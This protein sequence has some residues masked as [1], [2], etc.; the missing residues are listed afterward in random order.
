MTPFVEKSSEAQKCI[1]SCL[2][3]ALLECGA[4]CQSVGITHEDFDRDAPLYV[5]LMD[6]WSRGE[7]FDFSRIGNRLREAG[8]LDAIGGPS[9]LSEIQFHAGTPAN[10]H[11]YVECLLEARAARLLANLGERLRSAA[12]DAT[13]DPQEL[14]E[15]ARA[16]LDKIHV[17]PETHKTSIGHFA[18]QIVADLEEPEKHRHAEV[19]EI[20][21]GLDEGAGPF[22]R[23]DLVVIAGRTKGGKSSFAGNLIENCAMQAR[24][25]AMFSFEMTGKQN[26]SRMLASRSNVDI[27]D[28]RSKLN[29]D[30]DLFSDQDSLP[31]FNLDRIRTVAKAMKTWK[32]EIF[33]HLKGIEQVTAEMARMKCSGGLDV[34]MIDYAQL[35]RGLRSKGESREREVASIS[36]EL[37]QAAMKQQCLVLLLSQLTVDERTGSAHLRE[38]RA[39]GQDANCILFIEGEEDRDDGEPVART[40]RVGAARSAPSGTEIPL[41]WE[42]RFTKFSQP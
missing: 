33:E 15:E 1:L 4:V 20:G 23:G 34:A 27:R 26:V 9:R 29:A 22:E 13:T 35:V 24:R 17:T 2:C 11:Y 39:L 25:C 18:A 14:L 6:S 21:M 16:T 28:L 37:K 41:L 8:A 30:K 5:A 36:Y 10:L 3:L 12:F 7:E 42:K 38:S 40:I 32:V 31:M 19:I